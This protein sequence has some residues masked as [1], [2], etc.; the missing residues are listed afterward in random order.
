MIA[1]FNKFIKITYENIRGVRWEIKGSRK[2]SDSLETDHLRIQQR[3]YLNKVEN[4]LTKFN[5]NIRIQLTLWGVNIG[6]TKLRQ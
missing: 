1:Y 5:C 2:L 4:I 6:N 3:N